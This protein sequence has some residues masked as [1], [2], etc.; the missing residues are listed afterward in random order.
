MLARLTL[1]V[2]FEQLGIAPDAA[3]SLGRTL[4]FAFDEGYMGFAFGIF[5]YG[6]EADVVHPRIAEVMLPL[7]GLALFGKVI[8]EGIALLVEVAGG[9]E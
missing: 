3:A 7:D 5:I 1:L 6:R 8:R 2:E 9:S 4:A